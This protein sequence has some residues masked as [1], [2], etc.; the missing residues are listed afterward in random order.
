M[1]TKQIRLADLARVKKTSHENLDTKEFQN[2]SER[3]LLGYQM[4]N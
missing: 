1:L 3:Y 2:S 4:L